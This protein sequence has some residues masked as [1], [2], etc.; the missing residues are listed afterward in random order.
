MDGDEDDER[1]ADA[2][3][4]KAATSLRPENLRGF[5]CAGE[6]PQSKGGNDRTALT[7]RGYKGTGMR[8]RG[9]IT[10]RT[11]VDTSQMRVDMVD[12]QGFRTRCLEAELGF[13]LGKELIWGHSRF[14]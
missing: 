7:E 2:A 5:G 9:E 14:G 12:R 8:K 1:C 3:N 13:V 11:Q 6:S 10:K 4:G